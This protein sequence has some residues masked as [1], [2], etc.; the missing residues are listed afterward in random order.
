[1]VEDIEYLGAKLKSDS[2]LQAKVA[3]QGEI[4]LMDGKPSQKV[5]RQVSLSILNRRQKRTDLRPGIA[6]D[7]HN[8]VVESPPSGS[9]RIVDVEWNSGYKIGSK[10]ITAKTD[11]SRINDVH[12]RRRSAG[13]DCIDGPILQQFATALAQTRRGKVVR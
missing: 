6:R 13:K 8:L 4:E 3:P 9:V 11:V 10:R 2:F 1:M 7:Y 12:W 5:T